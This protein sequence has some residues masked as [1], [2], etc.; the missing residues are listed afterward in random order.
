VEYILGSL[1]TLIV[2]FFANI[3]ARKKEKESQK[4]S[5]EFSQSYGW[6]LLKKYII[7]E[8]VIGLK[9]ESQSAKFIAKQYVRVVIVENE[10]YWISNNQLYVA[11]YKNGIVDEDSTRKVDTFS[12]GKDDIKKTMSIVEKL[13]GE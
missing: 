5:V 9:P 4:L 10:A 13:T 7:E 2:M 3:M 12:M 1:S 6:N 11:E 8:E